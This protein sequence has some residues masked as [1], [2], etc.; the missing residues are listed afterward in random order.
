METKALIAIDLSENS[1]KAVEYVGDMMSCHPDIEIVLLTVIREPSADIMPDE[2]ERKA[3]VEK[4][5]GDTL[6]HMEAAARLL[7]S[8]GISEKK[9]HIKIQVCGKLVGIAD[10]ILQEQAEGKYRTVVIGRRGVSK[11]QEFLF[12]SISK[13]VVTEARDCAV[14]VIE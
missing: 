12:G 6:R 10:L 9:V 3:Y 8:R 2:V 11:R 1:L 5:R 4:M 7:T 13:K 14:W